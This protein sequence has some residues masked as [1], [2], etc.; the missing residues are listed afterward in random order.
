MATWL[1]VCLSRGSIVPKRLSR[2]SCDLHQ[3][4]AQPFWFIRTKYEQDNSRGSPLLMA[5]NANAAHSSDD[6]M[7]HFGGAV[8]RLCLKIIIGQTSTGGVVSELLVFTLRLR[9]PPL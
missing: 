5:S 7:T 6:D 8:W 1:S 9:A 4:V 2:S 3:I